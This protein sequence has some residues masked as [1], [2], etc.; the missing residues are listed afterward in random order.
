MSGS[1]SGGSCGQDD[2]IIFALR[3][4]G[5]WRVEAQGGS[6]EP[7][8][9]IGD[10]ET[11]HAEPDVHS[12]AGLVFFRAR[13]EDT[14]RVVVLDLDT[15]VR[16]DLAEGYLPR[17]TVGGHLVYADGGGLWAAAFDRDELSLIGPAVPVEEGVGTFALARDASTLVYLTDSPGALQ[18]VWVTRSGQTEPLPVVDVFDG[19]HPRLS[20]DGKRLV[21]GVPP[22]DIN[23]GIW[24]LG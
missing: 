23:A 16:S 20:T 19:G 21:F 24:V 12:D 5:L 13:R 8:T 14:D 9:T 4:T 10:G 7:L 11:L 17:L 22:Q 2:T 15:G 1:F 6:C 3:E 18:L